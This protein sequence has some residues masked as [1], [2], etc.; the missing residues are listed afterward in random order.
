[1]A[2][3]EKTATVDLRVRMKESLRSQVQAAA[4]DHGISLNAE[5]VARLER[6]FQDEE[7][8]GGPEAF[9]ALVTMMAAFLGTGQTAARSSGHPDWQ[10]PDW[11]ADPY[12]YQSAATAVVEALWSN[13]PHPIPGL[14]ERE[15]WIEQLKGRLV[16]QIVRLAPTKRESG[17]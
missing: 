6:S 7:R 5:A 14:T 17:T 16:S 9:T 15:D 4:E 12:S 8:F 10:I 3:R 13:H 11:M 2:E 1:M